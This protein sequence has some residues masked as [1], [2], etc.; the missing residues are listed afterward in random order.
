LTGVARRNGFSNRDGPSACKER[1]RASCDAGTIAAKSDRV[2]RKKT[3]CPANA[4]LVL[5]MI[6][7]ALGIVFAG[8]LVFSHA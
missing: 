8:Y 5:S 4:V 6:V 2:H 1:D 3:W 7:A